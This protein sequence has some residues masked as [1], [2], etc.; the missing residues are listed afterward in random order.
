MQPFLPIL[1]LF[2]P[3]SPSSHERRKSQSKLLSINITNSYSGSAIYLTGWC[4]CRWH[5]HVGSLAGCKMQKRG[6]ET[7][8]A[9]LRAE[10]SQHQEASSL[11]FLSRVLR[12]FYTVDSRIIFY[13]LPLSLS[14]S[15]CLS[16]PELIFLCRELIL[17]G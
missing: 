1:S 3:L 14:F 11:S 10:S 8:S 9:A 6:L 15:P 5:R 2:L 7:C 13:C 12:R 4:K 17:S 16:V